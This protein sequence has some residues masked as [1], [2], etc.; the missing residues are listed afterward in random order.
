MEAKEIEVPDIPE[1]FHVRGMS[2]PK[3]LKSGDNIFAI[4][5]PLEASCNWKHFV[6]RVSP[7]VGRCLLC[8]DGENEH[9]LG[10]TGNMWNIKR[11]LYTCHPHVC[12]YATLLKYSLQL[13]L[14]SDKNG[15][16]DLLH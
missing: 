10:E 8:R 1:C 4:S 16:F 15:H 14:K 6:H 5:F 7:L 13:L 3:E 12:D 11:H 9:T 2:T